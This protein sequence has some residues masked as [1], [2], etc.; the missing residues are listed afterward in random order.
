MNES[1]STPLPIPAAAAAML[2]PTTTAATAA[3][4]TGGPKRTKNRQSPPLTVPAGSTCFRL[5]CHASRIGG[6]IGKSGAI[7]KQLQHQTSAR[8]RVEDPVPGSD[9]RVVTVIGN[10]SVNRTITIPLTENNDY[11]DVNSERNHSNQGIEV[12]AAQEALI[13]VFERILL[14]AAEADGGYF[15][16]G[17]LASCRLLADKS[18]IGSVIGKGGKVI[19]KIRR[20]SGCKIRVLVQDKLPSCALANDEMVEIEGDILAIKKALVSVAR[21]LQDCPHANKAKT[22]FGRPHQAIPRETIPNGLMDIPSPSSDGTS[23]ID[24]RASQQEIVFRM[25]CSGARVGS[26][27]GKSGTIVQALQN[28]SGAAISV[29]APV[30]D[31]DDRLI[32]I[33]AMEAQGSRNS[34]AQNAV[35][36]V[37]NRMVDSSSTGTTVSARLLISPNQMGCLLGK[38][39]SIIADMRKVTGAVIKIVGDHQVP[40]CALETDQLVVMTGEFANVRDALYSVTGRLRDN[41]FSSKISNGNGSRGGYANLTQSMDGLKLSSNIDHPPTPAKW[42]SMIGSGNAGKGRDIG[43]E[44]TSVKGGIELGSGGRSAIVASMSVEIIVPQ[45][46]IGSVYGENES[47]LNRLR[48]ISGAKVTVHEP[49]SG[50]TDHLVVISGTPDETQSAQSLLQ[51]FILADQ[52]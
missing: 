50:T 15:E 33:T 36:L 8:I 37:F 16:P 32:T 48:Q 18:V 49:R 6:V 44:S 25:L 20:E 4:A 24:S 31:C 13:R 34:P 17:G 1:Q 47:N 2:E 41:L 26:V 30:S 14:V 39:G 21:C 40:K 27:I 28:E 3:T 7:I 9:D 43:S 46:V 5:L 35:I 52:S 22:V 45:N 29:R 12:S 19:E 42:Q 38:G 23:P 10:S 11:F 51:A